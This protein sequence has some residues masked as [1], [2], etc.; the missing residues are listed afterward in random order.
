LFLYK[1]ANYTRAEP[2]YRRALAI[3]EASFG[4][5][6]PEVAIDLNNLARLLQA[7]NRLSDAES[8]SRR[9]VES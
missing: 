2:L 1:R 7:T 4:S 9:V 6:H 8:L 5:D 3:D